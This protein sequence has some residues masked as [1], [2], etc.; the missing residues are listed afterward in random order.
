VASD[1]LSRDA[2]SRCCPRVEETAWGRRRL[3][4]TES[5]RLGPLS[6]RRSRPLAATRPDL[7]PPRV[8][9]LPRRVME[10][11][12]RKDGV[13]PLVVRPEEPRGMPMRLRR[14]VVPPVEGRSV[15]DA[16]VGMRLLPV[17]PCCRAPGRIVRSACGVL[18]PTLRPDVEPMV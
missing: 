15:G 1:R 14:A 8:E 10:R 5:R 18:T 9:A 3:S 7:S 13:K 11:G 17:L 2:S 6:G 12:C 4:P 16:T